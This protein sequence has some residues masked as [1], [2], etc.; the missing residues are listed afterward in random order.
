MGV[1]TT[2]TW[3]CDRCG[4]TEAF[5]ANEGERSRPDDWGYLFENTPP[6]SSTDKAEQIALICRPCRSDLRDW[7]SEGGPH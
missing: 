4:T 6:R 5:P 1:A 7:L 3:T 2:V